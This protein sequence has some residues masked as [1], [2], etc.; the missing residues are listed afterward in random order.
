M[1]RRKKGNPVHGW[2]VLDKPLGMTSTQAVGAVRR[3]FDAQKAGHAGTLD[4][5]ATGILP[6]ALGEATKTVPFAVDGEKAYRFTVRFGI[7][8][9]TDDAEGKVVRTSEELPTARRDR[10]RARRLHRRDH[11]GAADVLRH[12]DRRQPRLRPRPQRRG[13]GARAAL[14]RRRGPAADRHA[15]AVRPC[16]RPS[17]ARAPTCAPSPATWAARSAAPAHVIGL[18]RTRVGGFDEAVSVKLDT[19]RAARR[20]ATLAAHLRPVEAALDDYSGPQRRCRAMRPTSPAVRRCS[21]AA[22]TLRSSMARP[23]RTSKA[24]FWRWA[25]WKRA[26]SGRPACSISANPVVCTK[27]ER[28]PVPIPPRAARFVLAEHG[29]LV[30][31]TATTATLLDDIPAVAALRGPSPLPHLKERMPDV[32]FR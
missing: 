23:M 22:A 6:I 28:V 4:P 24:A 14:D 25:S 20:R 13:G 1:A 31:K 11:P 16:W 29:R 17:A 8:T 32:D 21:C 18:R 30:Y 3:L 27:R 5:L 15:G 9:D 7:E 26:P 19:L 2:V 12:Q 10:Q